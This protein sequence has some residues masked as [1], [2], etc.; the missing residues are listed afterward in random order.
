MVQNKEDN[1]IH[2]SKMSLKEQENI[3]LEDWKNS[4]EENGE[5]D[6]FVKD[7]IVNEDAYKDK[8]HIRILYLL[9]E[10]NGINEKDFDLRIYI[11]DKGA[12]HESWDNIARWTYGIYNLYGIEHV[13]KKIKELE[14]EKPSYTLS[15]ICAV[16]VKKTSGKDTANDKE[17]KKAAKE[18]GEFIKNQIENAQPELIIFCGSITKYCYQ[19]YVI[20]KDPEWKQTSRG[21]EYFIDENG[22]VYVSYNHPEARV[23]DNLLYYGLIDAV[24][25]ILDKPELS[26]L[27]SKYTW[28]KEF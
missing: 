2:V 28:K 11:N 1:S 17:I 13:W 25:E 10:T 26:D 5:S 14:A 16:N 24:K 15:S 4:L 23:P 3:L 7:G 12:R 6:I 27:R 18:Y 19:K 22:R 9:K 21:I 20:Q 8:N